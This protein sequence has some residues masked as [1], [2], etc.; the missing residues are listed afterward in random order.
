MRNIQYYDN[1]LFNIDSIATLNLFLVNIEFSAPLEANNDL[2]SLMVRSTDLTPIFGH[3]F[4]KLD[5]FR[6][7]LGSI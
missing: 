7:V 3:L 6:N 2:H 5:I 4:D 1:S